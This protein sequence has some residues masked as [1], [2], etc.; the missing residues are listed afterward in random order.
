MDELTDEE[1]T[2][3]KIAKAKQLIQN[4]VDRGDLTRLPGG[5][6]IETF[7]LTD[8]HRAEIAK[9]KVENDGGGH[10]DPG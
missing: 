6:I 9:A 8:Q 5:M 10:L 3:L 2:A 7:K 4:A 1:I